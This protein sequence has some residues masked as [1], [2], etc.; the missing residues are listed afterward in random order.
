MK[1]KEK[2]ETLFVGSM[3]TPRIEERKCFIPA[4][5]FGAK[6]KSLGQSPKIQNRERSERV[7]GPTLNLPRGPKR[8]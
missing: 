3:L 4:S 1:V 6:C 2:A 7:R 5:E 8:S